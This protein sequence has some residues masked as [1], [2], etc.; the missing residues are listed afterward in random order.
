[1]VPRH[2]LPLASTQ[3]FGCCELR[4]ALKPNVGYLA[5]ARVDHDMVV[6]REEATRG[7]GWGW[8]CVCVVSE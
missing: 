7:V 8:G 1:M 6:L 4:Q 2:H 5:H 3:A